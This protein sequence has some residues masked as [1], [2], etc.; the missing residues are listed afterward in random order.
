MK[1]PR[2]SPLG[3]LAIALLRPLL[4]RWVDVQVVGADALAAT[5]DRGTPVCWA[6]QFRS[7]TSLVVLDEQARRLGL[8]LP[9]APLAAAGADGTQVAAESH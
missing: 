6:L 3:R 4:R 8:P 7:L 5:L 2:A 1:P 9:L